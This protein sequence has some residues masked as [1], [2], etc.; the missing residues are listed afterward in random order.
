[1]KIA[2]FTD[3]YLPY[4]H[5]VV[6]SIQNYRKALETL[7]HEVY[8]VAPKK[9][10]YE[11][12]DDHIIRL[13]SINPIVFDNRPVSLHYPGIMRKLDKY[14]FDVVHSQTQFYLGGLAYMVAKRKHIPHI[15]TIHTLFS[16]LADDYPVAISA[17][18]IAFSIGFPFL[19]KTKPVLPYNNV[20]EIREWPRSTWT[21]IKKKQG[22]RLMAEFVNHTSAFVAP[23]HHLAKTLV[24]N[25]A[26]APCHVIPNGVFLDQYNNSKASDSLVKKRPGEKLIICVGRLSGEKRQRILIDAMKVLKTPNVRL[27]LVGTGPSVEMIQKKTH[28]LGLDD[29]VI[30]AGLQNS[31]MVAAMMKQADVFVQASYHFDNQPMVLLEAIASGLPIVYCDNRLKEGLTLENALLTKGRSGRAFAKAFDELLTDDEKLKSMSR[32][33]RQVAKEFDVLRLAQTM[34]DLYETAPIVLR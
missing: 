17:G 33:S 9:S 15:T 21:E 22:W 14:E 18:L 4:V 8:I 13:P 7:G 24:E 1:M 5:G 27:V 11:D 31:A 20:K 3:D 30:F 19:F 29:K 2:F 32:A 12:N 23:S 28:D 16:E 6:T 34:V 25:G 10:G 26:Q